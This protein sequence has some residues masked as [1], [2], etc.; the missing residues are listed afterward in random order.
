MD[1]KKNF[2]IAPI[3]KDGMGNIFL[4][5]FAFHS[6]TLIPIK[7]FQVFL[8]KSFKNIYANLHSTTENS[9]QIPEFLL[10]SI[11]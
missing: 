3:L 2:I 9:F 4:F 5:I 8:K 6:K 10:Y 1:S 7:I 11:A